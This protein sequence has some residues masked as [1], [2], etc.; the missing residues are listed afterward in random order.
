MTNNMVL[1]LAGKIYNLIIVLL[2]EKLF[3]LSFF[4]ES[5][6]V[7]GRQTVLQLIHDCVAWISWL[8]LTSRTD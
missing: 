3:M 1:I 4:L 6:I 7:T 8:L 5:N 2:Y